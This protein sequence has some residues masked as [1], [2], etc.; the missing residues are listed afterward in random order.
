MDELHAKSVD[1]L[2]VYWPALKGQGQK[3]LRLI[4]E[5]FSATMPI[6]FIASGINEH[7]VFEGLAS[8]TVDYF[9]TPIRAKELVTRIRVCFNLHYARDMSVA[10]KS[11]GLFL[12]D[13]EKKQIIFQNEEIPVTAK[14]FELAHI[15]MQN[16][17]RPLSRAAIVEKIWGDAALEE[18]RTLDTHISRV[19]NKLKLRP[20]NGYRL[21][22]IYGYGYLLNFTPLIS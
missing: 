14:E 9:I 12:F 21:S 16:L 11:Y 20:E 5:N 18:S 4:R 6:L 7:D 19:R 2:V 1:L 10:E 22:T 8:G 13:F 3:I 17:G 15:L